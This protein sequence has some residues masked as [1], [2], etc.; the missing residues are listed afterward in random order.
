MKVATL[1]LHE[2]TLRVAR[3]PLIEGLSLVVSPGQVVTIMGESGAGKSSLLGYICGTLPRGLF[4]QGR[5]V[6]AGRDVTALAPEHRRVGILFQDDLLFPHLSV[7]GNLAFAVPRRRHR[8]RDSLIE[9]ALAEA[10][11]TGFADRDPASLSG[12]QR[13][14][15]A[16]MRVLLSEPQ[17]LL[18]DEPFSKL[19]VTTKDRFRQFVFDHARS[20]GVPTLLVTHDPMDAVAAGGSIVEIGGRHYEPS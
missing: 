18:L 14:R 11:L 19:D 8:E 16:V 3:Q 15:V 1:E 13:A 6:I 4:A 10:G 9:A 12:G 2:V 20:S 7:G 17:A 5:V